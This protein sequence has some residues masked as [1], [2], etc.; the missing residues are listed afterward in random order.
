[1]DYASAG[2]LVI[3]TIVVAI[4]MRQRRG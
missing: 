2:A 1:M 3:V 4:R